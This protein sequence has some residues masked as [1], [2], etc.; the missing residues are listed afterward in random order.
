MNG[1]WPLELKVT[2][3]FKEVNGK[4]R[5]SIQHS[6]FPDNENKS[7]AETGWNESLDKLD[8]YLSKD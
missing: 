7:M 3:T 1:D 2:V 4:T 6:G 8:E 5:L